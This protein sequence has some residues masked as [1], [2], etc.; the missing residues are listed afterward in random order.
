[1]S[2]AYDVCVNAVFS[3]LSDKERKCI[4]LYIDGYKPREICSFLNL[5]PKQTDNA[6]TRAKKTLKKKYNSRD[7][8]KAK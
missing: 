4:R 8:L 7:Y 6:L 5:T 2:C 1:M 3:S